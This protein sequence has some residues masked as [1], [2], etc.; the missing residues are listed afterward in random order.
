MKAIKIQ[1]R[2]NTRFWLAPVTW[3][4][5]GYALF[6][7]RRDKWHFVSQKFQKKIIEAINEVAFFYPSDLVNTKTIIPPQIRVGDFRGVDIYLDT[8]RLGYIST[9]IHFPSLLFSWRHFEIS[10]DLLFSSSSGLS[11]SAATKTSGT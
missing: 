9:T 1:T 2:G 8:S 3:S 4:I 10:S 7:K 11:Q 6:C 5:H